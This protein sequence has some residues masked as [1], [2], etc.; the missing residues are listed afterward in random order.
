[1]HEFYVARLHGR[2]E[3]KI[4][5]PAFYHIWICKSL[6]VMSSSTVVRFMS[7]KLNAFR[8]ALMTFLI[9]QTHFAVLHK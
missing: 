4:T 5:F 8:V 9:C 7:M 3:M 2:A 6:F 1:M